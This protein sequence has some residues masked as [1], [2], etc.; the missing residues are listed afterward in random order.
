MHPDQTSE[1]LRAT[2]EG[3]CDDIVAIDEPSIDDRL[4][5]DSCL[6]YCIGQA[7]AVAERGDRERA[8]RLL[9]EAVSRSASLPITTGCLYLLADLGLKDEARQHLDRLIERE[10]EP[11]KREVYIHIKSIH[12]H[13][14]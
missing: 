7:H 6:L 11:S 8:K 9:R 5:T 2:I 3:R 14:K 12:P 4:I 1:I 10:E 13:F